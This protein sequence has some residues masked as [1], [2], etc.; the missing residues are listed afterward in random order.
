MA[1]RKSN[2]EQSGNPFTVIFYKLGLRGT[3]ALIA[4]WVSFLA[5]LFIFG[6]ILLGGT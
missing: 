2:M 3:S 5:L 6:G 4:E 1:K